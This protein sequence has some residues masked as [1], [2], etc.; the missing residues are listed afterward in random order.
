M[1]T[2][3]V[4]EPSWHRNLRNRRQK[5]RGTVAAF[6][7]GVSVPW[8]Q[9]HRAGNLL[10]EHHG[11]MAWTTVRSKPSSK[12]RYVVCGKCSAQH[13]DAWCYLGNLT[14]FPNCRHCAE[15]YPSPTSRQK[16]TKPNAD[17]GAASKPED[18]LAE[19][20]AAYQ[21]GPDKVKA[22]LFPEEVQSQAKQ[23]TLGQRAQARKDSQYKVTVLIKKVAAKTDELAAL[24]EECVEAMLK[25]EA[26]EKAFA[27]TIALENRALT[28]EGAKQDDP[29]F[30]SGEDLEAARKSLDKEQAA[31]LQKKLTEM[32]KAKA[33][34]DALLSTAKAAATPAGN[35]DEEGD[36]TMGGPSAGAAP[37]PAATAAIGKGK[38]RPASQAA[39]SSQ[40]EA[41]TSPE[42]AKLQKS[43]DA[44]TAQMAAR[45]QARKDEDRAKAQKDQEQAAKIVRGAKREAEQAAQ[46]PAETLM[47]D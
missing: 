36:V 42:E 14:R 13:S 28:P 35:K 10:N 8:D 26:A 17:Q 30:I 7:L 11:S 18:V 3:S 23:P 12:S 44:A 40:P 1:A 4:K 31:L 41:P 24:Q 19:L 38:G 34:I 6:K 25:A 22:I 9:L 15:P 29:C 21:A 43:V 5:A 39:A 33:E 45:L 46:A 16:G 27:D 20:R 2:A 47:E 32:E 37:A